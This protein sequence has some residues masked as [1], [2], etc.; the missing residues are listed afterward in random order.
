MDPVV[1]QDPGSNII[2]TMSKF[3]LRTA[4]DYYR[5]GE[6]L[7][8]RFQNYWGMQKIDGRMQSVDQ[9]F[10]W[11]GRCAQINNADGIILVV[12]HTSGN[13]RIVGVLLSEPTEVEDEANELVCGAAFDAERVQKALRDAARA[14][15]A[16]RGVKLVKET[17][18]VGLGGM[19]TRRTVRL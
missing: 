18:E 4:K 10:K 11:R 19:R 7:A 12:H 9:E 14:L 8:S 17:F 6:F 13:N 3:D 15:W 16:E 1:L 2:L 5:I